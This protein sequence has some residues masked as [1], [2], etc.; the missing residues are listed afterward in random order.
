ML[1]RLTS[2]FQTQALLDQASADWIIEC[3]TWALSNFDAEEFFQRT[4]LV[5]PTNQ[6]F[7]GA[8]NSI[9][10]K[11]EN[12]FQHTLNHSGLAHWPFELVNPEQYDPDPIVPLGLPHITRNSKEKLPA[13]QNTTSHNPTNQNTSEHIRPTIE[14]SYNPQQTLKAEDMASTYAHVLAQHMTVHSLQMPPGGRDFFMEGTEVL[15]VFLGFGVLV[16]NSAYTFRGGCGSCYN[17]YANRQASLSENEAVFALATFCVLKDIPFDKATAHL[18]KHL[19]K[20][21]KQ[22]IHQLSDYQDIIE[23]MRTQKTRS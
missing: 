4:K 20:P 16:A 14:V 15:A 19:R 13:I 3:F 8:V 7:P 5:Q 12:I 2:L 23:K 10:S 22:A 9:Q 1:N 11:A 18:K 17:P 6:F 21:F